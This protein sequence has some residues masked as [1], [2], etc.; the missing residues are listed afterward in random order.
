MAVFIAVLLL[1]EMGFAVWGS[2]SAHDWLASSPD[3]L[4]T[5]AG[6]EGLSTAAAGTG[7]AA[8]G[9]AVG[10]TEEVAAWVKQQTGMWRPMCCSCAV[11]CRDRINACSV[12]VFM[13]SCQH[14]V[15]MGKSPVT[16]SA[17]GFTSV[18]HL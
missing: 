9:D 15:S 2:D 1:Q 13:Q 10:V 8:G 17:T 14:Q 18:S 11:H 4:I 7:A 3:G 12:I 5:S 6:L 16:V